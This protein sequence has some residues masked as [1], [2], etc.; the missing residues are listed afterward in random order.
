MFPI[1]AGYTKYYSTLW[2]Y[3]DNFE[4]S[5]SVVGH[6]KKIVLWKEVPTV[7][8]LAEMRINWLWHEN[9][10]IN[11]SDMRKFEYR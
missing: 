9:L 7:V 5:F 6:L 11:N 4:L 2:P 1:W 3:Q 10:Y 8:T